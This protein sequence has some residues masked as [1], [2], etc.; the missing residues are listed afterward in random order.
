M[1]WGTLAASK[2][3]KS[4]SKRARSPSR[5]ARPERGGCDVR[6]QRSMRRIR[7]E[8]SV[9]HVASLL[10]QSSVGALFADESEQSR[11]QRAQRVAFTRNLPPPQLVGAGSEQLAHEG[12]VTNPVDRCGRGEEGLVE[13]FDAI[14]ER[15][16]DRRFGILSEGHQE[17]DVG[18]A[19]DRAG[20]EQRLEVTQQGNPLPHVETLSGGAARSARVAA[21]RRQR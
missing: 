15:R 14:G 10:A 8:V 6:V 19:V 20:L 13:G 21:G 12:G 9:H 2:P 16:Q 4:R 3:A 7:R 18:G 1:S 5:A 11:T 17:T